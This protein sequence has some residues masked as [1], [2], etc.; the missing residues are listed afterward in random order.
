MN[1]SRLVIGGT[2][3]GVG[4]REEVVRLVMELKPDVIL[5]DIAMPGWKKLT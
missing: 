4:D 2:S 3:S 1:I 5:M